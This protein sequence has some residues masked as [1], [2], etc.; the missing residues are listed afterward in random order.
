MAKLCLLGCLYNIGYEW[1]IRFVFAQFQS[2]SISW[3]LKNFMYLS[4]GTF[5]NIPANTCHIVPIIFA[6]EWEIDELDTHFIY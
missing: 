2:I 4:I 3:I 1:H 6:Y 5:D